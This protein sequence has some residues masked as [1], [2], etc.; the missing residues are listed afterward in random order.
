MKKRYLRQDTPTSPWA[1]CEEM[2]NAHI[3]SYLCMIC[4]YF[5]G[6]N[7]DEN[8][9]YVRCNVDEKITKETGK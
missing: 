8:G 9:D 3:G 2:R 7:R 4:L 5:C 1:I 6:E